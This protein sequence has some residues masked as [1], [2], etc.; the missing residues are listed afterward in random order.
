MPNLCTRAGQ[1]G[2]VDGRSR[3]TVQTNFQSSSYNWGSVEGREQTWR[4]LDRGDM[5]SR[6]TLRRLEAEGK[7]GLTRRR[8]LG[9]PDEGSVP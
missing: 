7:L 9:L 3:C 4:N 6:E 8:I 2:G 5:P 1:G